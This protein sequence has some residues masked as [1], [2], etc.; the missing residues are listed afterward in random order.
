M[1]K[2]ILRKS[3][4]K[5]SSHLGREDLKSIKFLCSEDLPRRKLECLHSAFEVFCA[6]EARGFV[7]YGRTDYLLFLLDNIGRKHLISKY[8]IESIVS[9]VY[10]PLS[11][12]FSREQMTTTRAFLSNLSAS[13]SEKEFRTL[14]NFFF[15]PSA[16][17]LKY[18]DIE[19]MTGAEDLFGALLD[20]R[21]IQP[22]NLSQL[23]TVLEIIGRNDLKE[24]VILHQQQ[25]QA[26]HS[27]C[28]V[29]QLHKQF[30]QILC[31]EKRFY[32]EVIITIHSIS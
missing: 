19:R 22:N 4:Y 12:N 13:F 9:P 26:V 30:K 17:A 18:D 6:L 29:N 15:D 31:I 23:S 25:Q 14:A 21:V 28:N 32:N 2:F 20:E 3:L 16:N 8:P 24:K 11:G 5:I 7:D 10:Q 27:T 1:S